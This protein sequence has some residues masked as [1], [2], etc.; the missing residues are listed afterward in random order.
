MV[1]A[2][3]VWNF[4]WKSNSILSWIVNI[5][6]AF[7]IVKFLILPG[8]GL[9]FGTDYPIVV[10]MS[11]SMEHDFKY[12]SW[13]VNYGQYYEDL[14]ITKTEFEDFKFSNGFNKGDLMIVVGKDK[15]V[16]GDVIIFQAAETAPLIHRI[17][18]VENETYTTKGDHNLRSRNDEVG[19]TQNRVYGKAVLR[20]PYLGWI[21]LL[22]VELLRGV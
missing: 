2:I 20:I 17:V 16:L 4:L 14:S 9:A 11:G 21:K 8:I 12:D 7:I 5:I 6:L 3:E 10:V 22:F 15:Y 18:S 19:I 1:T 13:W